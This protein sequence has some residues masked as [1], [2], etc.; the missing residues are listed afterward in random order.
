M[1]THRYGTKKKIQKRKRI[2]RLMGTLSCEKILNGQGL[3]SFEKK[4][5]KGEHKRDL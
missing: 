2:N 5:L 3:S 1:R 4:L